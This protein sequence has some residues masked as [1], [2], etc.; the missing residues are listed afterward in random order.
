MEH[1]RDIRDAADNHM[2]GHDEQR[3]LL[4]GRSCTRFGM[5]DYA[6]KVY[7]EASENEF[8]AL[9]DKITYAITDA[10]GCTENPEH[11][12][13]HFRAAF[14]SLRGGRRKWALRCAL[15]SLWAAVRYG[16]VY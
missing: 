13:P 2:A 4:L 7:F 16:E 11:V 10:L 1:D 15:R 8:H 6:V 14:A 3:D 12:C 5:N 9:Q